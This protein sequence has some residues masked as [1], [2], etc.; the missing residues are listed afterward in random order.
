[1]STEEKRYPVKTRRTPAELLHQA[2]CGTA[3]E[4]RIILL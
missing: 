4:G 3:P 1:M 2:Y